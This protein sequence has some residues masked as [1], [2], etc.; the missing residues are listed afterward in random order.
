MSFE[1]N[2]LI[3]LTIEALSSD[4]NGIGHADGM[5][6][7]VPGTVPGDQ[8]SVRLVKLCKNYAFGI[9]ENIH[10]PSPHRIKPDCSV[11]SVCGGCDFRFMTY[12]AE[13]AEKQTFVKDALLRLGGLEVEVAPVL[14]SPQENEYRNKVQYPVVRTAQGKVEAGFYANRSHR[15]VPCS[16]CRLQPELLNQIVATLCR[17]ME[18]FSVSAYDEAEHKGLVRHF[19]LRHGVHTGEIMVCL[20]CN[21]RSLPHQDE[22]ISQLLK[23]HPQITTIVLNVNLQKTNVV[24]G[25]E[26]IPLYGEGVIH[27]TLC[28]VPVTLNPLSFYQVN[29]P[30]AE[31]LYGVAA[32]FAAEGLEKEAENPRVLLDLYCGAGTIGL[33]MIDRFDALIGVE[34]IPQAVENACANA[35]AL[36]V[37]QQCRFLCA[38]AGQAAAQLA[39]EKLHPTVI[40]LDPPRK[41]CDIPTLD[42]VL[43]MSPKRIV[44]VSCN[45]STAARDARYL[46]DNGYSIQQ[47]QPVDMFPRTKHVE[48]VINLVRKS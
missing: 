2:Q 40:V 32:D 21:G 17:L 45:P 1:K 11:C 42:A 7:F 14:P 18:R 8:L 9:I 38:D 46:T 13:L 4:G 48:C 12:A 3:P 34:I 35:E 33:S 15:V 22:F 28:G 27:D 16:D 23:K 47:V 44:M 31:Q 19:Y 20:V 6:V 29:T 41:G 25:K 10:Q 24:T 37:A 30:G 36:G 26:N 39:A 43:Q 5:A